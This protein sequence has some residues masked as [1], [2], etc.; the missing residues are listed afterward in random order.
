M[1]V[2]T[3]AKFVDEA[4]LVVVDPDASAVVIV[5]VVV[6][7]VAVVIESVTE[8]DSVVAVVVVV[9]EVEVLLVT[10]VPALPKSDPKML[11]AWGKS[12]AV[13]DNKANPAHS[14]Q[15][16]VKPKPKAVV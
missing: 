6:E 1:E 13:A 16:P 3:G 9:V 8:L 5:E 14:A 2:G 4:A 12:V 7:V 15:N 11:V 10:S